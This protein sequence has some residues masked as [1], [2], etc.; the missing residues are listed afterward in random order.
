MHS[1]L[2]EGVVAEFRQALERV[3]W[4]QPKNDYLPNV[5]GDFVPLPSAD[6]FVNL[7]SDHI[8]KPVLWKKSIESLC[9]DVP[10]AV[11]VEVGPK[12]V[13]YDLLGR[14]WIN[15][16]RFKTDN[17]D[18]FEESFAITCRELTRGH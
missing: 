8:R 12:S 17:P 10:D 7:L 16:P 4:T 15:R 3:C 11:L 5:L 1:P 6:V 9:R 13:L 18:D 14:R 2:F